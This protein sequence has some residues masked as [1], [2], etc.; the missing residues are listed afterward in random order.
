ME[1]AF[2]SVGARYLL[3][4]LPSTLSFKWGS[5]EG[6]TEDSTFAARPE[7]AHD[8]MVR[9]LRRRNCTWYHADN[10]VFV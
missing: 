5:A 7:L 2:N 8:S 4:N 6:K 3:D 9:D 10:G 1:R